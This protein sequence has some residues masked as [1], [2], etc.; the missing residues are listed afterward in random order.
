MPRYGVPEQIV[1]VEALRK[2]SVGKLD[3]KLLR[4]RSVGRTRSRRAKVIWTLFRF[5]QTTPIIALISR[6]SRSP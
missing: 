1:F 5:C 6:K 4:E 3:K 2:T